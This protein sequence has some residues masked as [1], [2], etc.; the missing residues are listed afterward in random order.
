MPGMPLPDHSG[1]RAPNFTRQVSGGATRVS[2]T[3][4]GWSPTVDSLPPNKI[5]DLLVQVSSF[6]EHPS[7]TLSFTAPGDDL[8]N[9]RGKS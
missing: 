6:E 8:D 2:S 3:P 4:R 1:E 7:V 9:G 5:I